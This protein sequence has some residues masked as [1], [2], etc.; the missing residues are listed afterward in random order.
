MKYDI[1]KE[2]LEKGGILAYPTETVWGFGADIRFSKSLERIF[3]IKGREAVK[4]MS[5]LVKDNYQA[6]RLAVVTPKTEKFLEMF[7]PGPVTFVLKAKESVP[8]VITGDTGFVGL[9]CSSHA[10]VRGLFK[11]FDGVITT[12]S[13]NR[14]GEPPALRREDLS[15]LSE[16]GFGEVLC[17][18]W[19]EPLAVSPGSTVVKIDEAGKLECLR[20]GDLDFSLLSDFNSRLAAV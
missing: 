5:V 17:V 8:P 6:K 16:N 20:Q 7:W 3:E 14:S 4:A 19:T 15:W 11:T 2:H 1:I 9:R 18:D 13:A 12:T 10:F